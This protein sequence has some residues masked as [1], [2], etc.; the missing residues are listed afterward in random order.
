MESGQEGMKV[1]SSFLPL[2]HQKASVPGCGTEAGGMK[3]P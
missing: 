3:S 2:I 1:F